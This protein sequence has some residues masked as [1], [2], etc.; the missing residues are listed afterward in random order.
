[1]FHRRSPK[2]TKP[3]QE[4]DLISLDGDIGA[5]H[6][7]RLTTVIERP[8]RLSPAGGRLPQRNY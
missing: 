1:V 3:A 7:G 2:Y 6:A 5:V 8:W 4:G